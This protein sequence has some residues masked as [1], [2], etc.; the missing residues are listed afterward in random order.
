MGIDYDHENEKKIY[1][2]P[3]CLRVFSSGQALGG[4]KRSHDVLDYSPKKKKIIVISSNNTF[5]TTNERL[6]D[7]N[8]PAPLDFDYDQE[9]I[10]QID[11]G[12]L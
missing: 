5:T 4:H 6:I 12:H 1:D 3:I 8:L 9:E 10:S 11:D 2:C 7:L